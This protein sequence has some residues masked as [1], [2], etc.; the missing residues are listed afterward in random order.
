MEDSILDLVKIYILICFPL[1]TL[2]SLLLIN[3]GLRKQNQAV[4]RKGRICLY[5]GFLLPFYRLLIEFDS[6]PD[7]VLSIATLLFIITILAILVEVIIS[8]IKL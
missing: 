7:S 6:L 2:P 4:V 3:A 5:I 8:L 1:V